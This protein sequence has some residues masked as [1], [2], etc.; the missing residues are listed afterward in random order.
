[1]EKYNTNFSILLKPHGLINPVITYK[2]NNLVINAIVL[3]KESRLH[4]S[5]D[6]DQGNNKFEIIFTNKINET[7]DMAVEILEVEIEGIVVDRFKW[8]SRYYPL[9]PEP[10]ASQQTEPLPEYQSSATY[11]GWNGRWEL[12]FE[13]PIFTWIHQ[14][15]NLGWIYAPDSNLGGIKKIE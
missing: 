5:L 4:F 12:N 9:Y 8:A 7:P 3:D 15:E 1:M 13:V 14:L 10:W 11:M 6:L 2:L